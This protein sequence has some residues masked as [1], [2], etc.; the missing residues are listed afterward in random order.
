MENHGNQMVHLELRKVTLWRYTHRNLCAILYYNVIGQPLGRK[1]NAY[2]SQSMIVTTRTTQYTFRETCE[3]HDFP[4]KRLLET[5]E[6][7]ENH[8]VCLNSREI[9]N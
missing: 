7:T 6:I 4:P 5:A 2:T 8:S 3:F 9:R 1:H